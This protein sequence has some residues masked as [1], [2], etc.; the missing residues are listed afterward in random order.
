ML[1]KHRLRGLIAAGAVCA[2]VSGMA[3]AQSAPAHADPTQTLVAVGSDTIQDVWNGL[4]TTFGGNLVGSYNATNPVSG[5]INEI[6]TPADGTSGKSCSFSRPNGSGQGVA[7]LRLSLNQSSANAGSFVG[8]KPGLG[9]VDIARS[10][11]GPDIVDTN[12]AVDI[13]YIPFALD[14]VTGATGPAVCAGAGAPADGCAAFNA[15]LGNGNTFSASPVPTQITQANLFTTADLHNLYNCNTAT[16][17]GVTYW[18]FGSPTAQPAGSQ[19]IDLYQPQPGSG[20]RKFWEGGTAINYPDASPCVHDHIIGGALA[21]ANDGNVSVPVEEHDGTAVATDPLGYGPFS[22][23]QYISQQTP[24]HNPRFHDAVL[25]NIGGVSPYVGGVISGG[26]NASFPITRD[27]YNV[28]SLA[29]VTN[30]SDKLN[31]LLDGSGSAV[32]SQKTLI[33]SYGFATIGAA[34]GE[35]IPSLEAAP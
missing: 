1:R 33:K 5:G 21:P 18:P 17:G 2:A 8:T 16:E 15:D 24:T 13:Q 19:V 7:A 14:A 31:F 30:A 10:S 26:L 9:C 11:S 3:V 28:V 12:A 20:T 25:D 35:I 32:C 34:C 27:V 6:I 29:R 22:I 4:A 23:A